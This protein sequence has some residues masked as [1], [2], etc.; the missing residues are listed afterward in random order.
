ME[1]EPYFQCDSP[2]TTST[3]EAFL[4][5]RVPND[6]DPSGYV[7]VYL[8]SG[9]QLIVRDDDLFRVDDAASSCTAHRPSSPSSDA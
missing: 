6:R 3:H 8:A 1:L 7:A 4:R 5:V 9:T 2:P